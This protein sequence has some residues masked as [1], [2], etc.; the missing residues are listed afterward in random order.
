[1]AVLNTLKG[2][3]GSSSVDSGTKVLFNQSAAPAGWTK[4]T[5]H[6]DKILRVVSGSAGNG[7]SQSFSS[8][9][10]VGKATQ[11]HTLSTPQIAS[12]THVIPGTA[13]LETSGYKVTSSP[14]TN[15]HRN[16]STPTYSQSTN[17]SGSSGGHSHSL[18]IDVSFVDVIIATKD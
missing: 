17:S 10:G 15:F 7:G 16:E 14:P 11:S 13:V 1:M 8:C 6:N 3:A 12:H 2:G 9:F 4:D 18:D 5:T